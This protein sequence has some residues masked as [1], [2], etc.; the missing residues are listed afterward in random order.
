M[1]GTLTPCGFV[2]EAGSGVATGRPVGSTAYLGEAGMEIQFRDGVS[3]AV[4]GKCRNIEIG[5][6]FA[7]DVNS[8]A[9]GSAQTW[10]SGYL[11]SFQ[12]WAYAKNAFDKWSPR[13]AK[14]LAVLRGI[15][16]K[17]GAGRHDVI[18]SRH[19]CFCT[20]SLAWQFVEQPTVVTSELRQMPQADGMS[21]FSSRQGRT[22]RRSVI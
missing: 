12:Q 3:G 7:T 13:L 19:T 6:K 10:T 20:V 15:P 5:R 14:R 16:P 11:N 18:V 17:V 2:A 4:I 9:V 1:A 22:K 8:G 21:C